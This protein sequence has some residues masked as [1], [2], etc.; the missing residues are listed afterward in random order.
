MIRYGLYLMATLLFVWTAYTSLTQV[1]SDKRAV[2]RRFGR[3][4]VHKPQPGLHIGWPWGID[5]VDLAP[6]GRV[7]SIEV[8]FD[9][10]LIKPADPSK[11][12]ELIRAIARSL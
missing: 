12:E 11:L 9:D 5:R 2:I 1:P 3:I 4:L 10:H 6:V 8:G 7:R